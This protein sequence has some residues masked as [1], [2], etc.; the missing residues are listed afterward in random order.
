MLALIA[1]PGEV[2]QVFVAVWQ[3]AIQLAN[4][5]AE[6]ALAVQRKS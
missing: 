4:G 5:A 2:S 3:Q 1:W 6:Q